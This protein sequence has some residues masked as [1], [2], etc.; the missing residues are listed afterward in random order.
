LL[1]FFI[2]VICI[3][4][5]CEEIKSRD[6]ALE[7]VIVVVVIVSARVRASLPRTKKA[8][9]QNALSLFL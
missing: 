4:R 6:G 2:V 1:F 7:V 8:Q 5:R 9:S 3:F